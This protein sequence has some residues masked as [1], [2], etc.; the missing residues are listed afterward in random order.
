MSD[1]SK[2]LERKRAELLTPVGFRRY[3]PR[4]EFGTVTHFT[5]NLTRVKFPNEE[6]KQK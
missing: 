1:K 6:E 5:E 2:D 3:T 4:G